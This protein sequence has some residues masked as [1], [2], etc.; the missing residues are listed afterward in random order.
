M[1]RRLKPIVFLAC[2]APLARLAW[3][4]YSGS[5]GANPVEV[6]THSTGDWTLIFLLV[7]LSVM[8]L[9]RL[10]DQLWLIRFR[11]MFGLF[12]FFYVTLHFL[13]YI[14]LDKFFDVHEMLVDIAK[15]EIYYRW[16]HRLCVANSSGLYFDVGLDSSAGW[17]PVEPSASTD[18]SGC[19]CGCDSLLLAGQSG[20]PQAATVRGC[21]VTATG[22]S[23]GDIGIQKSKANNDARLPRP[24][25]QVSSIMSAL[26]ATGA[27]RD[28]SFDQRRNAGWH[29]IAG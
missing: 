13:T 23:P 19:D 4:A 1:I 15:A 28:H 20:C 26:Y 25:V 11:R 27:S 9:R 2:L 16:V 10:T 5:L 3:K 24:R 14:W 17:P 21:T 6:I 29:Q 18:L 8:P 7:T 22:I 12:S